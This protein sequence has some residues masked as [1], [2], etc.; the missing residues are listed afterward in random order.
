M[1]K[2]SNT[3]QN[4]EEDFC[5]ASLNNNSFNVEKEVQSNTSKPIT[6]SFFE[7]SEMYLIH[8]FYKITSKHKSQNIS[9]RII[10]GGIENNRAKGILYVILSTVS[11]SVMVFW[12]K[13]AYREN[14]HL[15][16]FD[17]VLVRA[18]IMALMSLSQVLIMKVNVF[19]VK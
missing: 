14:P 2:N 13:L 6:S 1:I 15:N 4:N 19:D 10:N 5:I 17:Y 8:S 11:F 16:G 9:E 7:E 18:T 12:W 3:I